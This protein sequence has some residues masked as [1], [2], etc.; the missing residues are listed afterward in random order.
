METSDFQQQLDRI[1]AASLSQKNVLT[2]DEAVTFTGLSRSHLYKLT[3]S[4]RIPH[5]KPFGKKLYFDRVE[6]EKWMLQNPIPT[7][8]ELEQKA[9]NYC[10]T[11]I[12]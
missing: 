11:G 3:C 6:L 10:H 12:R 9:I 2:F 4:Q 1:E 7:I 5:C 8:E